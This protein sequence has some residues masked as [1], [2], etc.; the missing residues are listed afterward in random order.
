M[1]EYQIAAAHRALDETHLRELWH[2]RTD[3]YVRLAE[4]LAQIKTVE[5]REDMPPPDPRLIAELNVIADFNAYAKLSF[6]IGELEGLTGRTVKDL[7]DEQLDVV[8]RL[9]QETL[10][11][12]QAKVHDH[13]MM[14]RELVQTAPTWREPIPMKQST[15]LVGPEGGPA[16]VGWES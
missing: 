7:T 9:K 3:A 5:L 14:L 6:L 2:R 10:E 16:H 13:M 8:K 4:W 11:Q 1:I 12:I 15:S